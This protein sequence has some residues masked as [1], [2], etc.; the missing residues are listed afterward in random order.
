MLVAA[1]A[2]V[3]RLRALLASPEDADAVLA[4]VLRRFGA[5]ADRSLRRTVLIEALGDL[6]DASLLG[7]LHRVDTRAE[8]G[9]AACRWLRTELALT[10]SVLAELPYERTVDL[11]AAARAAG[12]D[13]LAL[14][15][16]GGR[17]PPELRLPR[18]AR[19]PGRRDEG[20]GADPLPPGAIPP[21]RNPHLAISPGERVARARGRDR[22]VLDRLLHDRDPR[23]IAALLDNPRV[24]E[25]DAVRITAMRPTLPD[26][27]S[28]VA[29][30]PR[31]GHRYRVRKA[32]AFNP[33]APFALAR[34]LLPTLLR[35][36]LEE[37]ADSQALSAELR[38][39]VRR[40]L[41]RP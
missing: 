12:E 2:V 34:Q 37:L 17:P 33:A 31:W 41:A 24:T 1:P 21:D 32:L 11:Y 15:F 39:E 38:E 16:L 20:D 36:H 7:V 40:L 23:V 18:P 10:P 3:E 25:R 14:R 26:I 35:Q 30:H 8:G 28:L 6:D 9:D 22:L 5:V 4:G 13:A 27:L 29:G 19:A